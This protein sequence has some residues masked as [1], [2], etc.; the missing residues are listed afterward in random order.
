[1]ATIISAHRN[2][3]F[4]H[5]REVYLCEK[6]NTSGQRLTPVT[7]TNSAASIQLH[8]GSGVSPHHSQLKIQLA[9]GIETTTYCKTKCA[10][11]CAQ[12]SAKRLRSMQ[13]ESS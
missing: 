6:N 3:Q 13:P 7:E 9:T 10:Q 5:T 2:N 11:R 12:I 1:M 4:A 8:V